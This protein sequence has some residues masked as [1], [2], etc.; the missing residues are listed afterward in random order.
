[1]PVD[2]LLPAAK[3]ISLVES[4]KKAKHKPP[5]RQKIICVNLKLI[6]KELLAKSFT[7]CSLSFKKVRKIEEQRRRKTN[8]LQHMSSI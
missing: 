4:V 2:T 1:M 5:D 6:P 3:H 8:C 7:A